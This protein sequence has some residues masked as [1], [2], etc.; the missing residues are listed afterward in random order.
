MYSNPSESSQIANS[1]KADY[2]TTIG[3]TV[4]PRQVDICVPR[5]PA[6]LS[7]QRSAFVL[8]RA[9]SRAFQPTLVRKKTGLHRH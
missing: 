1:T 7:N 9:I 3:I 4:D 2:P 5:P 8:S 6:Q